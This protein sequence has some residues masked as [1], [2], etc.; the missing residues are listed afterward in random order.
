MK[1]KMISGNKALKGTTRKQTHKK[2]PNFIRKVVAFLSTKKG[3][4]KVIKLGLSKCGKKLI[5]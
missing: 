5:F 1:S 4:C 2:L 3:S